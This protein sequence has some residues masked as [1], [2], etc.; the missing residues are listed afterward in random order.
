VRKH[1]YSRQY[2]K[3]DVSLVRDRLVFNVKYRRTQAFTIKGFPGDGSR[4]YDTG[5]SWES[6]DFIIQK[7][8]QNVKLI[9]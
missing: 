1:Y 2:G 7:L 8:K 4:F 9:M 6:E 3:N 5:P